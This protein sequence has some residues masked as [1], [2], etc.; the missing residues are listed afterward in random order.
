M[1]LNAAATPVIQIYSPIVDQLMELR[2]KHKE[3]EAELIKQK[4]VEQLVA[5]TCLPHM[6]EEW[7]VRH[8]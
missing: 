4:P 6:K 2:K 1:L 5:E 7:K 8:V 3:R